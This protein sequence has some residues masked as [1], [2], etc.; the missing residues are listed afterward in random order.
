MAIPEQI[1]DREKRK[2]R[3]SSVIPEHTVV[4]VTVEDDLT[5]SII[6]SILSASDRVDLYT[7][8][9]SGTIAERVTQI[10]TTAPSVTALTLTTTF[11]YNTAGAWYVIASKSRVL[12]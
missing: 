12:A 8:Q 6:D 4:A 9:D 10:V 11:T 1:S 3:E 2:F 7:W 5:S